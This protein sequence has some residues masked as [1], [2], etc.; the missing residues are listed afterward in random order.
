MR[1]PFTPL[2]ALL[3]AAAVP[4]LAQIDAGQGIAPAIDTTGFRDSAHHWRNIIQPERFMQATGPDQPSYGPKQTREIADNILLFQRENGGWPKDYDM[5]AVLTEA[6]KK[7]V[8]DTRTNTDTSYD[9]HNTHPQVA[10]LARAFVALGDPALRAACERGLEF[11]LAS[12]YA[13]GGFP[14]WWPKGGTIAKRITLNDGV[15]I[16]ILNVLKDAADRAPH[17]AWLDEARR[18]RCAEAVARGTACLLKMQIPGGDGAPTGWGQQHDEVTLA[19]VGARTFELPCVAPGD[20]TEVVQFLM[21]AEKPAPEIVRAVEAAIAWLKRT[22]LDGIAVK[23]VPAPPAEF[24]RHKTDFD[25]VVVPEPGAPP[26]WARTIEPGTDRPIF[27]SRDGK[28]VYSLAEVDRER[29]T[30]SGWYVTAPRQLLQRDY[31]RWRARLA[32][33]R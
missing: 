29:R 6:Q 11:M 26:L 9:N 33:G 19:T 31:P 22:Q 20:T 27:A 3:L 13:N 8:R 18:V 23:R 14:Q 15:M 28:K 21:R 12:Q 32:E 10:Y 24:V 7:L 4:A 25:V 16:G 17:F 2:A 1:S 5:L 30:G